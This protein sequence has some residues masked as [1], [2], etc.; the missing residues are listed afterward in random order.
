[1]I[2][3][4]N[5]VKQRCSE[6]S[7]IARLHAFH[8]LVSLQLTLLHL[9]SVGRLHKVLL[10]GFVVNELPAKYKTAAPWSDEKMQEV[11]K[12]LNSPAQDTLE[13]QTVGLHLAHQL[14]QKTRKPQMS[15]W[16]PKPQAIGS[17]YLARQGTLST[18][19]LSPCAPPYT[20]HPPVPLPSA[21]ASPSTSASGWQILPAGQSETTGQQI[22]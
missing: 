1:M 13:A 2:S 19:G 14:P 10:H 16:D 17:K 3:Q 15:T 11:S 21:F 22:I 9:D 7:D 6:A 18:Q 20:S 4:G 8:L 12:A 5:Q